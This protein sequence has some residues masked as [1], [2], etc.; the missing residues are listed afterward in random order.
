[1]VD[2]NERGD[3][4]PPQ[5]MQLKVVKEWIEEGLDWEDPDEYWLRGETSTGKCRTPFALVPIIERA[6]GALRVHRCAL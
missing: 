3:M 1:M 4:N 6:L 5:T 2:Y